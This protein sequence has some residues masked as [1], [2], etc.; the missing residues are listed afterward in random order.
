MAQLV[1]QGKDEPVRELQKTVAESVEKLVRA[2]QGMQNGLLFWGRRLPPEDEAQ[3]IRVRLDET[4]TFLESLQAYNSPG[5][6]KSFRYGAPEVAGHKKG[7]DSLKE[8]ESLRDLAADLGPAASFLSTAEAVLPADHEWAGKAK[9]AR[10]EVLARLADPDKRG[11]AGLRQQIQRK[12]TALK[13]DYVRIY[14][15]LHAKARL[16]VDEDRR[17]ARLARDE[18]LQ[19]LRDLSA[20]ELMPRG[21]LIDWQDRLAGLKSCFMLTEPEM[22]ISPVCTHCGF[23]PGAEP[24]ASAADLNDLDDKLDNLVEDWTRMLLANLEAPA[25][26]AN[27]NLLKPES[28]ELVSGFVAKR[29][30]PDNPDR[31]FIHALGEA[32]SGL[33]KVSVTAE[34]LRQALLADGSPSTPDEM[35]QRFERYLEMILEGKEPAKVRIVLE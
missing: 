11:A 35:K 10:G 2:Q 26:R 30:L 28:R 3:E 32:L 20:I 6:F 16:G 12:L 13:R 27:L 18:R 25:V 34:A 14:L 19:A 24:A 31:D 8:V 15:A 7:I 17:K 21:R 29:A 23:K 33:Q 5:K 9:N 22:Q 1:T 4:K